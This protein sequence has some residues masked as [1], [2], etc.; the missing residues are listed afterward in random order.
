L[1]LF[2]FAEQTP[3]M[4][5]PARPA[6]RLA[7]SHVDDVAEAVIAVMEN[8]DLAGVYAVGGARPE[9]YAWA[10]IARTALAAVGRQARLASVPDWTI[11]LAGLISEH[12]GGRGAA[13]IFTRGKAREMLHDDWR[14]ADSEMI[15]GAPAASFS[16]QSGFA[17]AVAWYRRE[18]W[19]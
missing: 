2:R 7:L 14:V 12:A 9:G 17:D 4:P 6:A 3:L 5:I 18:G 8:A 16:L 13:P 15:P 19:L 10:E 1:A 11:S